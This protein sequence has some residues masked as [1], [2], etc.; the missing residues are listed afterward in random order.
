MPR[1]LVIFLII[2]CTGGAFYYLIKTKP[3]AI[4]Q[5]VEEKT[6]NV[7]SQIV[8][9]GS[10]Q[11]ILHLTGQVISSSDI[12][13]SASIEA[14][15]SKRW[16]NPGDK[17]TKGQ[18]LISFNDDQTKLKLNQAESTQEEIESQ[19]KEEK[20]NNDINTKIL[21]K[22]KELLKLSQLAVK[23]ATTLERSS[24]ASEAQIEDAKQAFLKQQIAIIDRE[25]TI[26]NYENRLTILKAK[27]KHAVAQ[28]ALAEI[29]LAY[30]K[31]HSPING[32]VI[33]TSVDTAE[34]VRPGTTLL[35][36]YDSDSI[37]IRC[38]VSEKNLPN[39]QHHVANQKPL[40]AKVKM[41]KDYINAT[42]NRISGHIAKGQAGSYLYLRF[43]STPPNLISGKILEAY[44]EL[45]S[46][47]N[48]VLLPHDALYRTDTIYKIINNRLKH[49]DVTWLGEA[50]DENN[51]LK[52]LISSK[53]IQDK[54]EI[55]TSKFANAMNGLKITRVNR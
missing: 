14:D 36:I 44:L 11:P 39:L 6:W 37:E 50:F 21:Q 27:L 1:Y 30:T 54:D 33:E 55:L 22:E 16:V 13:I 52:I 35:Q 5:T 48:S 2:I 8:S 38:L 15:V 20:Y 31:V 19:I 9:L 45:P 12:T 10:H 49:F 3:P 24:M 26:K 46:V 40:L 47:N 7:E 34:Q 29:N 32:Y 28:V 18:L 51:Q 23:R 53:T 17:I 42:L 25:K 43:K 4:K 41:G